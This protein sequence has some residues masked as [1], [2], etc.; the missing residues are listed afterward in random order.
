MKKYRCNNIVFLFLF[1]TF[2]C[3]FV[4][5]KHKNGSE[6]VKPINS[7]IVLYN[8]GSKIYFSENGNS[9]NFVKDADGWGGQEPKYRCTVGS[10]TVVKFN[11]ANTRNFDL[12]LQIMAFGVYPPDDIEQKVSVFANGT[13]VAN[14]SVRRLDTYVAE[15]PASL[16]QD[17]IL[18]IKFVPEKPYTP[19]GDHRKLGMAVHEMTLTRNLGAQTK[20]KIGRWL[21]N[22]IV[23]SDKHINIFEEYDGKIDEPK[24][25]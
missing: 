10:E 5:F 24:Y 14:W 21:K 2:L 16:T 4:A 7:N 11:L 17:G 22:I 3:C 20:K 9:K 8:L 1:L 23:D 12:E 18:V 6:S 19:I 15:I 13:N 25:Y